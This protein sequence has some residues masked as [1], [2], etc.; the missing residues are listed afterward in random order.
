VFFGSYSSK[1]KSAAI[2][3]EIAGKNLESQKISLKGQYDQAV[4]EFLKNQKSLE[5]YKSSGLPNADLLLSKSESAYRNGDI[6]YAEN[7]LNLRTANGIQ[8]NSLGAIL[9]YN[10]SIALLEFLQGKN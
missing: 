4:Q 6:S 7:L 10:L 5:Y 9:Q 2:S 1:V 3:K 8:E